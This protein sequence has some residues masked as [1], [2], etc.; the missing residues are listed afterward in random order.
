MTDSIPKS[1]KAKRWLWARWHTLRYSLA[2]PQKIAP[3]KPDQERINAIALGAAQPG[4][5]AE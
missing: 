1:W 2:K 4:I 5:P 3:P